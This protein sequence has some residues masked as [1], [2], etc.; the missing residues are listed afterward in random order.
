MLL[1]MCVLCF[2]VLS[3]VGKELD[4]QQTSVVAKQAREVEFLKQKTTQYHKLVSNM[5]VYLEHMHA[6]S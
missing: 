2:R 5:K 4:T 3:E 1:E 6:H